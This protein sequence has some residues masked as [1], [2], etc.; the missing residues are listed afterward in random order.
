MIPV[1]SYFL[2][3]EG[4]ILR[5]LGRSTLAVDCGFDTP[6]LAAGLFI[7]LNLLMGIAFQGRFFT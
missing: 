2:I 6:L 3:S 5:P 4:R 7:A 1:P